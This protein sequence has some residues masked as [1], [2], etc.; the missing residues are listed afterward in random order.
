MLP[1]LGAQ[2]TE[3]AQ[4]VC[5]TFAG[6]LPEADL[7][8]HT[9]RAIEVCENACG[10]ALNS[11][12]RIDYLV[13]SLI[14]DSEKS[15][16][17]TAVVAVVLS[18]F[19]RILEH[20]RGIGAN[21][22]GVRLRKF[23]CAASD[24]L[25]IDAGRRLLEAKSKTEKVERRM[26]EM[27]LNSIKFTTKRG[28]AWID[29]GGSRMFLLDIA[30]GWF[31]FVERIALF[32]GEETSRRVFFEAGQSETFTT[33]ALDKGVLEMS[34]QGFL[35]ALDTLSE[36][37][38]GDFRVS[39]LRFDQA[40]ARITCVDAFE[41]W[42]YLQAGKASDTPVCH[43][44]AGAIQSFMQHTSGQNDLISTETKCVARGDDECEFIVGRREELELWGISMPQWGM[45]IKERAEAL[46]NLLHEKETA[47]KEIRNRN[48][49]LAAIN[50]IA[51]AVNQSLDL[52]EI[53]SLAI[54]ELRKIVGDRGVIIYLLDSAGQELN[55]AAQ[56]GF[57][58]EF[59]R[60]VSRLSLGEGLTGEVA[61]MGVPTA[62][63]DY[64]T[65]PQAI[66]AAVKEE[67]VCSLL[68][69]PLMAKKQIVGVLSVGSKTPYHFSEEEI[70]LLTMIGNQIGVATDN[71]QLHEN[72]KE[73]E[74]KYKTLIEDI[75]DGYFVCQNNR[76]VF[77]NDAFL[78]MHGYHR[79]EAL[80]HNFREFVSP[81][82]VGDVQK[83]VEKQ[84]LG[85]SRLENVEFLRLHKDGRRLPT[86]LKVSFSEFEGRPAV[87]GIS[88]DI[89][90]RRRLEQKVLENE[91]LASIGEVTSTLAH[92]IRNPL[93]AIKMTIQ[94]LSKN[95]KVQGFDKKRFQ[96]ALTEI[97]RLDRFLQDML[98]FAGPVN[99]KK[100]LNSLPDIISECLDLLRDKAGSHNIRFHW[101]RPRNAG[102]VLVDFSK[103]EE[104][105]LNILLNSMDAMPHGGRI[106]VTVED[107]ETEAGPMI[108]VEIRDTGS[109]ISTDQLPR[110]FDPFYST[111]TE[112]AGLGLSNAKRI[113]DAHNGIIQV[114]SRTAGGTSFRIRLPAE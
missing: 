58:E 28:R 64:R 9:E 101:K 74:R 66:E 83:T 36:A 81:D 5:A 24:R 76:V 43:F 37:G 69:V 91:R 98:H 103:M 27:K 35:D 60:M 89:S 2:R 45:T 68:A 86:E 13:Q 65:Y 55:V 1:L 54:K 51:T 48:A 90:E 105:F 87:I 16:I 25:L 14:T 97:K 82:C 77:A 73:S 94:L 40:Y 12:G 42:A 4:T 57:T 49:E 93:S 38:F 106:Y 96:L 88:R 22:N 92:E 39:E 102:K 21:R 113:V 114:E 46:E 95:L 67:K 72:L 6:R 10:E 41:G 23:V 112:G 17:D 108:Q 32:A 26:E 18:R 11:R 80:Q 29:V 79:E 71:A 78:D 3:I 109:G 20:R 100:E 59:V 85:E 52:K 107:V 84:M 62:Y 53:S 33:K 111:K 30:G 34:P 15:G 19:R 50:K 7:K 99:M 61:H 47:E 56:E 104:V 8:V 110:I 31:N 63:D 44:S 70:N 75:N